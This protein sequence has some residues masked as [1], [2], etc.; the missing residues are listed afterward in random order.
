LVIVAFDDGVQLVPKNWIVDGKC[1]WPS[2]KS[3]SR[4]NT[5]VQN[6]EEANPSWPLHPARILASFGRCY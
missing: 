4:Y 3:N 2:F 6:R 5:A 1:Y